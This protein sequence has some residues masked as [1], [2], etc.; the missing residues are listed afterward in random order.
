MN[1][2][3]TQAETTMDTNKGA[4]FYDGLCVLCSREIE[5]YRKQAGSEAF[6]FIDIT[7]PDFTPEAYGV[8][9][10]AVHKVMHVKDTTGQ[11]HT[12]VDAFRAIWKEL[13]KYKFLYRWTNNK[14]AQFFMKLG[15]SGFVSI[16]PYLPRKKV[17]C[18]TSPYCDIKS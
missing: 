7:S 13:P 15:Y 11:L 3:N 1:Y 6:N 9:P 14:A 16:R 10:H 5:H 2:M 18:E 4:I 8:D 12:G 17:N